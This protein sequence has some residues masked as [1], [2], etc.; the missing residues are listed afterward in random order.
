MNKKLLSCLIASTVII[1]SVVGMGSTPVFA[2]TTPKASS[3][4]TETNQ[5]GPIIKVSKDRFLLQVG[6]KFDF[7]KELGLQITDKTD[8]NITNKV[9][10]P[11][12][13]TDKVNKF[14][15]TIK[16]TDSKGLTATKDITINVI[17]IADSVKLN[18]IDD[19]KTYDLS[20][21]ITGDKKGLTTSLSSINNKD[22]NFDM[23]VSDGVNNIKK[24]VKVDVEKLPPIGDD[25]SK[26]S[27]ATPD[28]KAD[29]SKATGS[30][31]VK[32][33]TPATPTK[34]DAKD[35]S[36][37]SGIKSKLPKTGDI[38]VVGEVLGAA[39]VGLGSVVGIMYKKRK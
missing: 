11:T 27:T 26:D 34:S 31:T 20:K 8:G 19:V 30:G 22:S 5:A 29:T 18:N 33:T 3:S 37:D 15:F 9:K 2:D 7:A 17:K 1:G 28:S 32:T 35:T 23:T 16:S 12:I 4:S 24:T 10:I 39:V 25:S 38:G 13:S 14:T 6:Q 36:G 21:L